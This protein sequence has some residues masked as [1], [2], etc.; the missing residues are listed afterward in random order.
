VTSPRQTRADDEHSSVSIRPI[1]R[2]RALFRTVPL[3][4]IIGRE[5]EI[6]Q[7][8]A[9]LRRNDV[10]LVTLTGAGGIGKTRL[11]TEIA[12]LLAADFPDGIAFVPVATLR[13]PDLVVSTI[14]QAVGVREFPDQSTIERLRAGLADAALLLVLDN[15]EQVPSAMPAIAQL[16][17]GCAA[18]KILATSR[19]VLRILGERE[20]PLAPLPIAPA[21]RSASVE[22]IGQLPSVQLFVDRASA[23]RPDFALTEA[24]A[25][26]ISA[27]CSRLDG[28]PLAI[29]L[30]AMRSRLLSPAAILSRLEKRLAF[31]TSG[32][33][34]QPERL[35]TLR[36]AIVWSYD[37]LSS[38]EQRLFRRL[39]VF[40]GGFSLAAAEVVAQADAELTGDD[41]LDGIAALV[42]KGLIAVDN[43]HAAETADP[44]F[45]MLETIREFA[46]EAP[47]ASGELP[48]LRRAHGAYV[49]ELV[50][51]AEVSYL[52][53]EDVPWLAQLTA[54]QDNL[55][56]ALAW[57]IERQDADGALRLSA[58]AVWFWFVRGQFEEGRAWYQTILSSSW[59]DT[60]TTSRCRALYAAGI[61]AHYQGD[62][63]TVRL[64]LGEC[65][66]ISRAIGDDASLA[67]SLLLRGVA[68][69]DSGDYAEAE[70][71]FS[72][73]AAIFQHLGDTLWTAQALV[74]L[75]VV[76]FGQ[77]ELEAAAERCNAG[78]AAYRRVGNK[79]GAAVG[80]T[81]ALDI[82]SFVDLRRGDLA[83][84]M[85]LQ[86]RA[87][88]MRVDLEDQRG[89]ASSIGGV[90][91][92][93]TAARDYA[94]AMHL[95][96]AADE[97]RHTLGI[98]LA[99]PESDMYE[100]AI[101]QIRQS[102]ES[103][104]FET[105][106]QAGRSMT[107]D[108]ILAMCD[109]I[110]TPEAMPLTDLPASEGIERLTARERE[111][112]RLI[113]SGKSDKDIAE[114]LFI[115]PRTAMRHVANVFAKLGVHSRVAA[116]TYARQYGLVESSQE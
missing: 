62:E 48:A 77:G 49:L 25:A 37:L 113:A 10:R 8:L 71:R 32:A 83:G 91:I 106:R 81:G 52:R 87:L 85:A 29:E 36:N 100:A 7:V 11:A 80:I 67:R 86:R 4:S 50:E 66:M 61:L 45:R 69:E 40:G 47:A 12:R 3:T 9:L 95:F 18:L 54:E 108:D 22:A 97:L 63:R 46:L 94:R 112:L 21:R 104:A 39:A 103:D 65:E 27:I 53:G 110:L 23:V 114:A 42:D 24:N 92:I 16:L 30:A 88:S 115:S 98:M 15:L 109:L 2:Q 1:S 99:H 70:V 90:A 33:A 44:R 60:P 93:A 55:R 20:M 51:R 34:T 43:A 26:T 59:A 105:R 19:G 41:I 68:A 6:A 64:M 102:S 14:A 72:E 35:Q 116:S 78:L 79:L 5:R 74:H 107:R 73:S 17:E 82:L 31:L 101:E 38:G 57:F 28:L 84:A 56:A 76:A 89:I 111:E 75:G 96:G 58:A 13:D